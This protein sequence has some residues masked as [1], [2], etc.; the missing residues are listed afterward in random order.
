MNHDLYFDNVFVA[1]LKLNRRAYVFVCL[2]VSI[3]VCVFVCVSV[4]MCVCVFVSVPVCVCV[5]G[6]ANGC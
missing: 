4:F 5:S 2:C 3:N 6:A 1:L